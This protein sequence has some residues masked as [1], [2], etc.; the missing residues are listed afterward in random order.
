MCFLKQPFSLLL[1]T[2]GIHQMLTSPYYRKNQPLL[3]TTL[4]FI[5]FLVLK[6]NGPRYFAI[7]NVKNDH[8]SIF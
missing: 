6:P 4:S 3:W 1:Q 8:Y 7:E 2:L 5:R